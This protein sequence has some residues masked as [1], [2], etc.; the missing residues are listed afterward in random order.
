MI[1]LLFWSHWSKLRPQPLMPVVS[2]FSLLT[3]PFIIRPVLANSIYSMIQNQGT[4]CFSL[5]EW[6]TTIRVPILH[7]AGTSITWDNTLKAHWKCLVINQCHY[8]RSKIAFEFWMTQG[9]FPVCYLG[10]VASPPLSSRHRMISTFSSSSNVGQ[11]SFPV[12]PG[13]FGTWVL[14]AWYPS[15]KEWPLQL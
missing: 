10:L 7:K 11:L 4:L 5:L 1:C 3:P 8:G 14:T 9:L 12:A 15:P 6:K 13:M 2:I